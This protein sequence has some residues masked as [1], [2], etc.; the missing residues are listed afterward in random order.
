MPLMRRSIPLSRRFVWISIS[1]PTLRSLFNGFSK[2]WINFSSPDSIIIHFLILVINLL[3]YSLNP[4]IVLDLFF[5]ALNLACLRLF[6]EDVLI[7]LIVVVGDI[8]DIGREILLNF[9]KG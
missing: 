7:V 5:F 3:L 2:S 8:L 1:S 4:I 6:I 9:Q